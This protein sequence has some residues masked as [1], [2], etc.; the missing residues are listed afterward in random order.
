VK[1]IESYPAPSQDAYSNPLIH[2]ALLAPGGRLDQQ[3]VMRRKGST[4]LFPQGRTGEVEL[5]RETGRPRSSVHFVSQQFPKLALLARLPVQCC[6]HPRVDCRPEHPVVVL[7]R[8]RCDIFAPGSLAKENG[9]VL[10]RPIVGHPRTVEEYGEIH[11]N[12]SSWSSFHT[13]RP[14]RNPNKTASP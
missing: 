6:L 13:T 12:F 1:C 8:K 5:W 3:D 7:L 4:L 11:T 10:D 14:L 2:L 9:S